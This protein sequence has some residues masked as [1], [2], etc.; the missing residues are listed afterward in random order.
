[1]TAIAVAEVVLDEAEA[2][3]FVGEREAAGEATRVRP[4]VS[5]GS[6]SWSSELLRRE[7]V[8]VDLL[9]REPDRLRAAG[10]GAEDRLQGRQQLLE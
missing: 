9:D 4:Q 8:E 3:A 2:K 10:G 6:L 1:M 7:G 5:A